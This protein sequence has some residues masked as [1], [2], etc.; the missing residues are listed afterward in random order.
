MV[1]KKTIRCVGRRLLLAFLASAGTAG[2]TALPATA[3]TGSHMPPVAGPA[4]SFGL[5]DIQLAP[6]EK[7]VSSPGSM[8]SMFQHDG[9]SYQIIDPSAVPTASNPGT[10]MTMSEMPMMSHS[11]SPSQSM[12]SYSGSCATGNCGRSGFSG[13]GFSGGGMN[14]HGVGMGGNACGPTCNPYLYAS[15]EGLYMMNTNVDNY[16]RSRNYVL[17]DFDF[18]FGFRATMGIVPDCRNGME[19]SFTGP[20]EW[21]TSRNISGANLGSLLLP[22]S[23]LPVLTTFNN[24][25]AQDQR[26]DAEYFSLELNRTL[27]G[28]EICK[29]LYGLRYVDYDE[30]YTFASRINNNVPALP[31]DIGFLNSNTQNQMIGAQVG[32]EMTFP[33]S[34]KVWSDFRGRAGAYANFAENDFILNNAGTTLVR[35]FDDAVE[36]AGIFEIGGGLRYYFNDDFHVRAGTELWYMTGVAT[37]IDQFSARL[38]P[39]TGRE[40]NIDDDVLMVGFSFGAEIKF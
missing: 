9:G 40:V 30:N 4:A 16:T 29:L 33:L 5:N 13:G 3:Q 28:W 24:A 17:D 36:L 22:R 21:E 32:A 7:I 8:G 39:N 14:G 11:V 25:T 37:A 10:G 2:V 1:T 18:E 34:C 20:F 23:G 31:T 26:Y 27:I 12:G 19:V 35:N 15:F 6:G 38:R